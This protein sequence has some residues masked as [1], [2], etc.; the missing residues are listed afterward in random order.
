MAPIV[1][2]QV[3]SDT[4]AV[5]A[6]LTD[7]FADDGHVATLA[8]ALL[9]GPSRLALVA[10]ANGEVA[11]HVQ[12]SRAWLDAPRRLVDVLVLS[13][14]GV[15]PAHQ[16][17]GLGGRL[18][19]AALTAA[20]DMGVPLVFLEGDPR[21]YERLGFEPAVELGFRSPSVRIPDPAFQVA[22]MASWK[23]WMTGALVYCDVFWT[24]DAVG[25]RADLRQESGRDQ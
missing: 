3:L 22:P 18:V 13:P 5:R 2:P 17:T 15:A 1:R 4:D 20:A 24:H 19:R 10:E 14:L 25:L 9:D 11:G 12:L 21:Y 6:V 23:R 16:G 8:E 7:A